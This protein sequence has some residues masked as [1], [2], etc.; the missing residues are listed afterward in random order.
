VSRRS[1]VLEYQTRVVLH[2]SRITEPDFLESFLSKPMNSC[3]GL[4]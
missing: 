3:L 4:Y 2:R 1:A